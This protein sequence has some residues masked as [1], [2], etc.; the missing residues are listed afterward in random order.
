MT[1]F[2]TAISPFSGL[3]QTDYILFFWLTEAPRGDI[4]SLFSNKFLK[5][6]PGGLVL[7]LAA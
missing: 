6:P 7:G 1:Y 2:R 3:Y 4:F 5:N